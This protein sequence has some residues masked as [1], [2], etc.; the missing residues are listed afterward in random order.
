MLM[1]AS[2]MEA[3]SKE[4]GEALDSRLIIQTKQ[5][6]KQT[7]KLQNLTKYQPR[8]SNS[9]LLYPLPSDASR[10]ERR[11]NSISWF[12]VGHIQ[13]MDLADIGVE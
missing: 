4:E 2:K 12:E 10:F 6:N 3:F 9:I 11:W 5:T 1:K 7:K 8:Y 13:A